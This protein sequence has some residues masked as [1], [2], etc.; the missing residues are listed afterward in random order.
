MKFYYDDNLFGGNGGYVCNITSA[1]IAKAKGEFSK[2]KSKVGEIYKID[3]NKMPEFSH[4]CAIFFGKE[5]DWS[6]DL[7]YTDFPYTIPDLFICTNKSVAENLFNFLKPLEFHD[8]IQQTYRTIEQEGK[9]VK[10]LLGDY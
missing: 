9:C 7:Q 4:F 1:D 8:R 5:Y 6:D 3:P 2:Y 10:I